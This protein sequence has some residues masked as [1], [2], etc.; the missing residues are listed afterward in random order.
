MTNNKKKVKKII[1][2]KNTEK[3]KNSEKL[4]T[5]IIKLI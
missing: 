3:M 5:L 4:V 1:F 2:F